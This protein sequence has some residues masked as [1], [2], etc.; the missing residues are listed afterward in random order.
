MMESG[1]WQVDLQA[2]LAQ[3]ARLLCV[4][5]RSVG[6]YLNPPRARH[7]EPA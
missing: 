1:E 7:S 3:W 2:L 6:T 4:M 5:M